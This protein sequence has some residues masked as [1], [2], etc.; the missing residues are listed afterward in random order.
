M[1]TSYPL[2]L[3]KIIS[4]EDN[5]A[6]VRIGDSELCSPALLSYFEWSQFTYTWR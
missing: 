4:E 5:E 1:H 3:Y 6:Q 2:L